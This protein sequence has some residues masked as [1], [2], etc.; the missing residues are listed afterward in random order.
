MKCWEYSARSIFLMT[1]P[2]H[3]RVSWGVTDM[4]VQNLMNGWTLIILIGEG[5]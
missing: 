1:P 2:P 3:F 5:L 4:P